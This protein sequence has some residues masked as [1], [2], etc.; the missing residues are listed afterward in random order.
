MKANEAIE[1]YL[2][3]L[4]VEKGLGK[5]TLGSYKED[6]S[7]FFRY[8]K[9]KNDTE[10]L[11]GSDIKDYLLTLA[12][13]GK[14]ASTILRRMASIKGFYLFLLEEGII[15][16]EIPSFEAPKLPKRLP[17][18]MSEEEVN[19]L[20]DAP[21]L[22]KESGVRDRAMLEVIYGSGLRVS[23][24]LDLKFS[25]VN[26]RSGLITIVGKG[27]KERSVPIGEFALSYLLSYVNGARKANKG[28][29]SSYIFLN[30]SGKPLSRIY[31]FKA[32]KSYG[33][34][35]GIET[36]ISPHTLR[37]SFATHLLE[38]GAELKAV[39]EMLGHSKIS[40]TQIYTSVSSRRIMSAYDKYSKR[41]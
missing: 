25:N 21:D 3:F 9:G 36:N 11:L 1:R 6:L 10:E 41:K 7:L 37:H 29:S 32:I 27:K 17:M 20:L 16:V 19:N 18:V 24:L 2:Q 33:A 35:A 38:H 13:D 34:K 39:Q 8:L 31:F 22:K 15:D 30:K 4:Q 5:D 40:T 26:F 23:E 12:E 28:A 14:S